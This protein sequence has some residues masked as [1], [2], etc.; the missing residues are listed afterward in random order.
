[1]MGALRKGSPSTKYESPLT[2]FLRFSGDQNLLA[3]VGMSV[4]I[5]LFLYAASMSFCSLNVESRVS[6][7][8]ATRTLLPTAT[9]PRPPATMFSLPVVTTVLAVAALAS[10]SSAGT[11]T[12]RK[13][14]PAPGP[15][16]HGPHHAAR[17]YPRPQRA[18]YERA[19]L[20]VGTPA[21]RSSQPPR[22]AW[23]FI[24]MHYSTYIPYPEIRLI[25]SL[26]LALQC[27]STGCFGQNPII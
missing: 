27:R 1:M 26:L 17:V 5:G 11:P 22:Y 21:A 3:D 24:A 9:V 12:H 7:K 14:N 18:S 16:R 6:D 20:L 10:A 8:Q 23:R 13:L 15:G 2:R 25:T 19:P 4:A